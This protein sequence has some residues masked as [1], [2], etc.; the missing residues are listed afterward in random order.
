MDSKGRI[1]LPKEVRERLGVVP[2]AE[3]EV[4]V[5]DRRAIVEPEDDPESIIDDVE[6]MIEAAAA[7]PD[8]SPDELEGE[9]R[10]HVET[11]RRQAGAND[12]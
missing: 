9:A 4:H 12:R 5:E 7:K 10:R 8:R 1:V 11:I 3:V 2:G 6:A